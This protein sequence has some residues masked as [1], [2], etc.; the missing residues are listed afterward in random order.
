MEEEEPGEES[1][2]PEATEEERE[3][4]RE[5]QATTSLFSGSLFGNNGMVT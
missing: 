2:M 1:K 3:D 4:K 5:T